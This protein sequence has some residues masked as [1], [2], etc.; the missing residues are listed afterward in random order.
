MHLRHLQPPSVLQGAGD[1]R[2]KAFTLKCLREE[3]LVLFKRAY[4]IKQL[5]KNLVKKY[6]FK[7]KEGLHI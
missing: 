6:L 1:H 5:S 3:P 4:T 2:S 7:R